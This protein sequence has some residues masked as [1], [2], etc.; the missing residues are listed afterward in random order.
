MLLGSTRSTDNT[1]RKTSLSSAFD[2]QLDVPEM[3]EFGEPP[4]AQTDP[5]AFFPQETEFNGKVVSSKYTDLD[6][7]KKICHSCPYKIKC[8]EY[9][10]KRSDIGIWGGMTERE[11]VLYR[12]RLRAKNS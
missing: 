9:A 8:L 4:C 2:F 12:R 11:R 10:L 7:V 5:E 1:E 3:T 6:M